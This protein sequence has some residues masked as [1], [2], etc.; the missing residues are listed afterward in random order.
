MMEPHF[1][2]LSGLIIVNL[3]I[4][5]HTTLVLESETGNSYRLTIRYDIEQVCGLA[6]LGWVLN[7]YRRLAEVLHLCSVSI[8]RACTATYKF[9]RL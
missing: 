3:R 6:P 9:N 7:E 2:S 1:F 8:F 4:Y 5:S